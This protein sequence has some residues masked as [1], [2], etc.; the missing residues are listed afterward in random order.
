MVAAPLRI[1]SQIA[2]GW[3]EGEVDA[4]AAAVCKS[5]SPWN[6][7]AAAA[8]ASHDA[9]QTACM[10]LS[11]VIQQRGQRGLVWQVMHVR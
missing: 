2:T 1:A 3:G 6:C 5:L 8:R 11:D 9:R 7:S 10:G 4:M